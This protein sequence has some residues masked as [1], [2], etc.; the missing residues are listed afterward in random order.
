MSVGLKCFSPPFR[1]SSWGV[2][3]VR[4]F[5]ASRMLDILCVESLEDLRD[6]RTSLFFDD[7][8]ASERVKSDNASILKTK[9]SDFQV[10]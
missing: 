10:G 7:S 4:V 1:R 5:Y 2:F 8:V 3:R 9:L 6:G